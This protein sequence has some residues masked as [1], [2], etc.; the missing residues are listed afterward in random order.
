M[1][2]TG[3][4]DSGATPTGY[5]LIQWCLWEVIERCGPD[6]R[7]EDCPLA[8][9][10][11]GVA[12]EGTGFFSIDDAIAIRARSSRAA[13]E[14]EMLCCGVRRDHLVLREFDPSRHVADVPFNR[15]WP[16]Y[17]A[18]DFGYRSPMVCLWLQVTPAGCVHVLSEYVMERRAIGQHA[19][20]I[21]A[22]DPARPVAATY[23][24]PAGRQKESTSGMACTELLASCG[25]YCTS[26][27]ST[28]AEGLELIRA[29]LDPADGP[30]TLRIAPKCRHLLHALEN[31]HY[32]LPD[33]PGR[34][35]KPVK[36]GPDHAI[37]ALRYFFVNR[38][39]P[40]GKVQRRYY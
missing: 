14:S 35:D 10:C 13:W 15:A 27:Y 39:Q 22:M 24:D 30:S 31:Y 28:V 17:R 37:D 19:K 18:I 33:D 12:R 3:L 5:R 38:M 40:W 16:L 34:R 2:E 32:P 1:P 20:A 8:A 29:A 25:I 6:R 21:L 4:P 36:D 26:R 7:C 9:D 11:R 23:V